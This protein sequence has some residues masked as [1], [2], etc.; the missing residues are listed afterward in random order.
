MRPAHPLMAVL[1]L[2]LVSALTQGSVARAETLAHDQLPD[3]RVL[4][5]APGQSLAGLVQRLYPD[6]PDRWTA[7]RGWIVEHNPHAFVD[8]DPDRLRADVRVKL[9][10]ASS[11]ATT[12]PYDLEPADA[13]A[14]DA[15]AG[16][17][18]LSFGQRFVFVDPAQ[19]LAELVPRLYPQKSELW[20]EIIDAVATHNAERLADLQA[21]GEIARGTRLQIPTIAVAPA[22]GESGSAGSSDTEEPPPAPIVAR[23]MERTG[24]VRAIGRSGRER[25]LDTGDPIRRGDIL[26]AGAEASAVI[27]FEDH[28]RVFLR[29]GTRLR[30]RAWNLPETGPGTRVIEL[31]EGAMRAIT[32]A[33]GNRAEDT[34]RTI[35]PQATLG[36]RGTEYAL[37]LCEEGGCRVPETEDGVLPGGLYVG[38]DAGRVVLLNEATETVVP[39]GQYRYVAG[40]GSEP[41]PTG[42]DVASILYT[43]AEQ[44]ERT[45]ASATDEP[46]AATEDGGSSWWWGVLGVV[47][48]GVA[49]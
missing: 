10:T 15:A 4:Y 44:A 2:A 22:T 13:S 24:E 37:R 16:E 26:R 38:V 14:D 35:T 36:V 48:L 1:V 46:Q 41:V 20:G 23:V 8:G 7:I 6:Q 30:V 17:A 28:E 34:Y 3:D 27:R 21:E 45:P 31:F 33:I 32:G 25:L 9:P 49:L 43:E 19:S 5:I 12:D 40:P 29:P 47:L 11:F 39:A 18:R 42:D